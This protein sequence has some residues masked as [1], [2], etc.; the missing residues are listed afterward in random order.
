MK[1]TQ[2]DT[3]LRLAVLASAIF[4]GLCAY[5]ICAQA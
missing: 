2:I 5:A 3:I 4:M 1:T